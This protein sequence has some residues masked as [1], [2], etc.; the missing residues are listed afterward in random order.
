MFLLHVSARRSQEALE[1]HHKLLVGQLAATVSSAIEHVMAPDLLMGQLE[2]ADTLLVRGAALGWLMQRVR[3][4]CGRGR[5][6]ACSAWWTAMYEGL[7]SAGRYTAVGPRTRGAAGAATVR[8]AGCKVLF[9]R[10]GSCV[11]H[12]GC[13]SPHAQLS[14]V[15][16]HDHE[17]FNMLV[18]RRKALE[19]RARLRRTDLAPQ[20]AQHEC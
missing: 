1:S 2:V 11:L 20:P 6:A 14:L 18:R 10:R 4:C 13:A 16:L 15:V 5:E 19:G 9:L 17:D 3:P 12:D 8:P 7:R